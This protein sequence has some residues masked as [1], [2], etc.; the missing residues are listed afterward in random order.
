MISIYFSVIA[1]ELLYADGCR[2]KTLSLSLYTNTQALLRPGRFD[3]HITMDLPNLEERR[4]IFE[5]HLRAIVLEKPT[6]YY[7]RRMASLSLGF[8]GAYSCPRKGC[9]RHNLQLL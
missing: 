9:S 3:R 1:L 6:T 5:H 8:S 4:E 7:S 2:N